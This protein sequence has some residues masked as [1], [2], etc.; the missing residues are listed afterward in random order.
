MSKSYE[1]LNAIE[2]IERLCSLSSKVL[3]HLGYKNACDC[4]CGMG[5]LNREKN[6]DIKALTYENGYRNDGIVLQYIEKA[7][8]Q[9]I[10]R[11]NRRRIK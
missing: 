11:E 9:K 10:H 7:V 4:F 2:T 3:G 1:S 8:M 6:V 5:G